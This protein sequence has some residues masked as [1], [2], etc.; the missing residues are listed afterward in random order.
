L[1]SI[2]R[3]ATAISAASGFSALPLCVDLDG[4]LVQTDSLHEAVVLAS[5]DPLNLVRAL[6][7]LIEGKAKFKKAIYAAASLDARTLPYNQPLLRYLRDERARGRRIVLITAA[8]SLIADAVSESLGVFDEVIASDGVRNVRGETKAEILVDRFGVGNFVYAGNDQTDMHVWRR[9]GGAILVNADSRLVARARNIVSIEAE[10][11]PVPKGI[12]PFIKALRPHQWAKNVLV[13]LPIIASTQLLDFD[14]WKN[15]ALLFVSF[16]CAASAIY[17]VND[18][19]DL[20]ADRQ[21][22]RKRLRPFASGS[23][24]VRTGVL[25]SAALGV[26]AMG[27]AAPIGAIPLVV[28]YAILSSSYSLILKEKAL[29]DVFIL[30]S[31]YTIRIFAGGVVSGHMVT[32]WLF[33]FSIFVFLSLALAKRVAELLGTRARSGGQLSRRAYADQDIPILQTMGVAAAFVAALVL[34][35]YLQSQAAQ[36]LYANPTWL[37]FVVVAVLFWFARVWLTTSR[38]NMDD[39]PVVWAVKDRVSQVLAVVLAAAMIAAIGGF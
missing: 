15:A 22:P 34:S 29:V 33:G 26:V 31:L 17:I 12:M 8:D 19:T 36:S 16:C 35:L 21:H 28:G 18:L 32:E 14:G 25:L 1:E 27:F 24:S 11:P 7:N 23:L 9:S 30:A 2:D 39:D 13:F 5:R 20:L 3:E 10:F 37:L 4:T 38:G 6:T